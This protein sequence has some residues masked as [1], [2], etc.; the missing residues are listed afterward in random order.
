MPVLNPTITG[1][2]ATYSIV[3]TLPPGITL[4]ASSGAIAGTPASASQQQTYTITAGNVTGNTTFTFEL[5]ALAVTSNAGLS[6]TVELGT[7][8]SLDGSASTTSSGDALVFSWSFAAMPNGSDAGLAATSS[9]QPVFRADKL[10]TYTAVLTVSDGA[11]TSAPAT[12]DILVVPK[13]ARVIT[14]AA[15][16]SIPVTACGDIVVPGNYEL[17]VDLVA[18]APGAHCLSIH[19][20]SNVTLHC[21][22]HGLSDAADFSSVALDV[23]NVQGFTLRDCL[24]S[25]D[26]WQITDSS[27]VQVFDSHI[28]ALQN[29][30]DQ[31]SIWVWRTPRLTFE[32]NV[33]SDVALQ[34]LG[35][36][37]AVVADNQL[38]VTPGAAS[39]LPF[40][41]GSQYGANLQ[42]LRNEID[43]GWSGVFS[44]DLQNALDDAVVLK[45][46]NH[47]LVQNNFMKNCFDAGVEWVGQLQNSV[48]QSNVIVNVG[49][50]A[51]GGW[52]WSS[53]SNVQFLQNLADRS[54]SLFAATRIY[55]LRPANFDA[56]NVSSLPA[57]TGVYFRHNLF[58]GNV[59]R[60]TAST[61]SQTGNSVWMPLY[62]RMGYAGGLSTLP[63]EVVPTDSQF[64]VTDNRFVRND[65]GH[66]YPAFFGSNPPVPGVVVD[67]GQNTC[68]T[69][70]GANFPLACK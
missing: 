27:D 61:G 20:T 51:I 37:D 15:S 69:P 60:G 9:M 36:D 66:S 28:T 50:V 22:G 3:P 4:D 38:G 67:G 25:T 56:Y 70:P 39:R 43:G 53:V 18:A 45:D 11:I 1:F 41:I 68:L 65:F 40:Q 64:D 57:D 6:Q 2:V 55:G 12:V 44:G 13:V 23:R 48:I 62:D 34:L 19:D 42:I 59:M 46:S 5:T 10:G 58:D 16:G 52:Y 26:N 21:N 33:V 17:T 47:A 31:A 7:F 63:G 14:P 30:Q 24:I 35:S 49:Y 54:A 8:V 29:I 32:F